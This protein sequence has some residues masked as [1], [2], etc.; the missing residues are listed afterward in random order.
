MFYAQARIGRH[1]RKFPF[2]KFR[3]MVLNA[4]RGSLLTAPNDP[5]ITRIGSFLR[6]YKLDELPQLINV[7]KGDM[8][9][10]GPRPEVERYVEIFRSQYAL[11]LRHPPGITDLATLVYRQEDKMFNAGNLEEQ[12]VSE[13]LPDKVRLSLAYQQQRSFVS[14]LRILFHTVIGLSVPNDIT[15]LHKHESS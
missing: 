9:L 15:D 8:Q 12:Y 3:S 6:K 11:L 13:I 7:F 4:D 5:R 10:V 14:D 1:F 2:L